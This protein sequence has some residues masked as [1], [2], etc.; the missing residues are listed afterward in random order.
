MRS[1]VTGALLAALFTA[2]GPPPGV[3]FRTTLANTSGEFPLPVALG[4]TSGIV[5]GI[6]PASVSSVDFRDAGVFVD[7][8]RPNA[9]ILTWLGG[10]CDDDVALVFSPT[11]SGYDI[12]LAI[13]QGIGGCPGAGILR[14]LRIETSEPI[15]VGAIT[16]S[17]AKTIELLLD[18]DCGPLVAAATDD[19]KLACLALIE[20]TVGGRV[21]EFASVKVAPDD[22]ACPG[23]ECSTAE[24][25][26]AQ[27][28]R[29]D[30]VDRN[31]Q[32]HTWRCTYREEAASCAVVVG[33]SAP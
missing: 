4:D 25:I 29:V 17:G 20:A 7:P 6:G 33:P 15:S 8:T 23:T 19:S 30:A 21:E 31:G 28:W 2:C 26:A 27:A 13:R 32:S 5:V 16:I 22:G 24:G 1:I 3:V 18:E 11:D 9:F 10:M 14:G 12:R